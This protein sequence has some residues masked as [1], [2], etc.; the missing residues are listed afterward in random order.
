[1]SKDLLRS[2]D[3]RKKFLQSER[4]AKMLNTPQ[5]S[6]N[7]GSLELSQQAEVTPNVGFTPKSFFEFSYSEDFEDKRGG[8]KHP[9]PP[10]FLNL[11]ALLSLMI[12]VF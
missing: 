7:E 1:M 12:M 11:L 2:A 8:P 5:K 6:T 4:K 9:N 10:S 3:R